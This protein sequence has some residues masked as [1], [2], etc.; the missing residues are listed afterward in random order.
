MATLVV[1]Y[2]AGEGDHFDADYY[3][4][5]HIPLVER[6]WTPFGL[7]GA[8]ILFPAGDQPLKAMVLLRFADQAAIDAALGCPDTPEVM[9]DVAKFTNIQP[10]IYRA[11]G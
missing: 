8:E 9:A 10:A 3:T 7:T 1:S 6:L 4:A 2:P 11:A 5:T